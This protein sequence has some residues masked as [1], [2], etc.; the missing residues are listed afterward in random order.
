M[1]AERQEPYMMLPPQRDCPAG[2]PGLMPPNT[3][4]D[5][6]RSRL[7]PDVRPLKEGA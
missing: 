2:D 3:G 4:A 6:L 1:V 5:S 7:I